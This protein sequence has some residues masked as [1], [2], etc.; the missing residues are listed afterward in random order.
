[1]DYEKRISY[2]EF[3]L[4]KELAYENTYGKD[5][6]IRLEYEVYLE[7]LKYGQKGLDKSL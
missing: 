4:N 5:D 6:M 3:K 1:M 7:R 2:L